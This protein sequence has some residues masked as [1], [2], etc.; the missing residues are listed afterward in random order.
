MTT[1]FDAT[2]FSALPTGIPNLPIGTFVLPVNAP[3]VTQGS[4]LVN[5]AQSNAWSCLVPQAPSPL[6]IEITPI[7]AVN[8][9][10]VNNEAVINYANNTLM[11]WTY[12]AQ[13]PIVDDQQVMKL[14][15]DS[16]EPERGPAWWFQLPYNKLVVLRETDLS[17][18][19]SKREVLERQQGNNN[20]HD[21]GDFMGKKGVAQPGEKPWFCYW[22]GTLLETFIYVNQTSSAGSQSSSSSATTTSSTAAPSNTQP[23]TGTYSS[24]VPTSNVQSQGSSYSGP[25]QLPNFPSLYPKVVKLEE[26]RIPRGAQSISPYCVQHIV[27]SDGSA[28]PFM[29]STNQP[30]TVYLNEA[31]PTSFSR[32][33]FFE[34]SLYGR[35]DGYIC[36]CTW[37]LT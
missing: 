21:T 2:P 3:S 24:S 1:T 32:R 37:E 6:Q 12:G 35:D 27:Q 26:R 7:P 16:E 8:S 13:A 31:M 11:S 29:N 4:C 36:G 25:S 14:V 17:M 19:T 9:P 28:I 20:W 34:Q 33:D 23:A 5:S 22:N 10:L 15:T 30:V 18:P